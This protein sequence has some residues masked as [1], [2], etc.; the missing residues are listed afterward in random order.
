MKK[1]L[2]LSFSLFVVILISVLNIE[3][4]SVAS[5]FKDWNGSAGNS[6]NSKIT[7]ANTIKSKADIDGEI[8]EIK[9]SGFLGFK[10]AIIVDDIIYSLNN[11]TKAL[12]G[13]NLDGVKVKNI[14]LANI[15]SSILFSRLAS[16]GKDTVF[17]TALSDIRAVD[18][19]TGKVKWQSKVISPGQLSTH[20][21]YHDGFLYGG[22]ATT[23][24]S[25]GSNPS[26]GFY[27]AI[28]TSKDD[29]SKDGEQLPYAWTWKMEDQSGN[30]FYWDGATIVKNAIVF[31]G[32]GGKV[33][34]HHLK[35]DHV[36]DEY[37]LNDK[38]EDVHKVRSSVHY[39]AY[40]DE[41]VIATQNSKSIFKIKMNGNKFDKESIIYNNSGTDGFTGGPSISKKANGNLYAPGGGMSANSF[42]IYDAENLNIKYTTKDYGTQ[43]YPVINAANVDGYEYTY[44]IDYKTGDLIISKYNGESNPSFERVPLLSNGKSP[45]YNSGGP[46]IASDGTIVITKHD[47]G[48]M[49][50]IKPK[51]NVYTIEEIETIVAGLPAVE[52]LDYYDKDQIKQIYY[53]YTLVQADNEE[54]VNEELEALSE[55]IDDISDEKV[56]QA[57][58]ELT[59]LLVKEDA[60]LK[61]SEEALETY[62]KLYSDDKENIDTAKYQSAI[63]KNLSIL[64]EKDIY[65]LPI[66]DDIKLSDYKKIYAIVNFYND[67]VEEVQNWISQDAKNVM[68][69]A[70][71][72]AQEFYEQA[73]EEA[74]ILEIAIDAL[75][76]IVDI[77]ISDEEEI[78]KVSQDIEN[79]SLEV[80][81]LINKDKKNR[82][83]H[84]SYKI[85]ALKI[86]ELIKEIP[87]IDNL[88]SADIEKILSVYSIYNQS[89]QSIKGY[90]ESALKTKL[91]NA[92]NKVAVLPLEDAI[93]ALPS[94]ENLKLSDKD[95]VDKASADFKALSKTNQGRVKASAKTKLTNLEERMNKLVETAE[96]AQD[97]TDE[98]NNLPSF[99]NLT[100]E[101]KD[102]LDE[103]YVKYE[104]TSQEV[105]D[106]INSDV[107][108]KLFSLNVQMNLL[109]KAKELEDKIKE[110][111]DKLKEIPKAFYKEISKGNYTYYY[112]LN[113]A[114]EYDLYKKTYKINE[115]ITTWNYRTTKAKKIS[116][117]NIVSK[118]GEMTVQKQYYKYDTKGIKKTYIK[119]SY[120][121]DG[122]IKNRLE[123][124][125]NKNGQLKST[126]KYGKAYRYLTSYN[127]K[128]KAIET[129]RKQ[130][131]SKGK[132]SKKSIKVKLRTSA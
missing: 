77:K 26:D 10:D 100:I 78:N 124:K 22:A 19:K 60:T 126:K 27:F 1:K 13:W 12:E 70:F 131:D 85:D 21:V 132:L 93:T 104:S 66:G 67:S 32:D 125:Y 71:V 11:N 89:N 53:Q 73:R 111:E 110:L 88:T 25:A 52:E 49:F 2:L 28:D 29:P 117:K 50:I 81:E 36:Y 119:F 38:F 94:V 40:K 58:N 43:S 7:Y 108:M 130:Y 65:D 72:I 114:N 44:F 5:E 76:N 51:S 75:P 120:K 30:G 59:N 57:N 33:V 123:Y 31:V 8:K 127:S 48:S 121:T 4:S 69:A 99:D 98:I 103:I 118:K 39:N 74:D 34:S 55:K 112:K 109:V 16:D 95:A 116:S 24:I 6:T 54:Y 68:D 9:G 84:L 79:A 97:I 122:K 92:N 35:K 42:S 129:T 102:A 3:A 96:K 63:N 91:T 56:N 62:G 46:I 113:T 37:D 101:D 61:D 45:T 87:E 41:V 107:R 90:V 20:V 23:N 105:K 15:G 17:V 80:Q 86:N 64:I 47:G 83:L 82:L 115:K 18:V 128:G 14:T 106:L